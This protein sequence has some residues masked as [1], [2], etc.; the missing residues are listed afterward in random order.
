MTP[1][2]ESKSLRPEDC[3]LGVLVGELLPDW[4]DDWIAFERARLR[5]LCV[6]ALEALCRRLSLAGR[7]GRAI[8]AGLAAV[9]AEPL[10]E[11]A[12]RVLISAHLRE[13]NVTEARRQYPSY[14]ELLWESLGIEPSE[15]LRALVGLTSSSAAKP[16]P[17]CGP[18]SRGAALGPPASC[19][20]RDA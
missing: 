5:Q 14:R 4:D 10:R 9:A 19:L 7:D 20:I 18:C 16:T 3:D 13:G 8:D 6:H 11:S 17:A 2:P 1:K 12:Q 15:S